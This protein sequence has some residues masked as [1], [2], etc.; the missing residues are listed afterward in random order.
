MQGRF[1]RMAVTAAAIFVLPAMIGA[2]PVVQPADDLRESYELLSTTFYSKV[3]TQKLL[4][5]AR[6]VLAEEAHRRGLHVNIPQF[7][8]EG[9]TAANVNQVSDAIT[10]VDAAVHGA[11]TSAS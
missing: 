4:D 3:D 1:R 7:H 8:D 6:A 11:A 5:G 9:S 2:A 10:H